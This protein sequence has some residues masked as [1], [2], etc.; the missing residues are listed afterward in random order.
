MDSNYP[1]DKL[2]IEQ[3][4]T[5]TKKEAYEAMLYT[6]EAYWENS[7]SNDLTDILSGG[8]YWKGTDYPID[9]AF[10]EYWTESIE[11]VR[12]DGPMFKILIKEE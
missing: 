11:K 10:W 6:L 3:N 12:R 4:E 8:E 7:R 1:S 5:L 2:R 9:S